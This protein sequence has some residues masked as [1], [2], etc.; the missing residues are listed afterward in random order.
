MVGGPND[1]AWLG[2]LTGSIKAMLMAPFVSQKLI[3][4]FAQ[5]QQVDLQLLRDLLQSGKLTAV[6][7]RRYQLGDTP[8]AIAY[9]ETG[10]ARGKVI[11]KVD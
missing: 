1:G 8:E 10:H 7:D 6:I 11:I 3:F 5:L 4:I 2:P 9:V